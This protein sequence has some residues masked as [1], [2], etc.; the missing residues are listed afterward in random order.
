MTMIVEKPAM[1][2]DG[3]CHAMTKERALALLNGLLLTLTI[4]LRLSGPLIRR[5]Y[6]RECQ[7]LTQSQ[8]IVLAV[9]L[10]R[11]AR[12]ECDTGL[13]HTDREFSRSLTVYAIPSAVGEH[14][15]ARFSEQDFDPL[16]ELLVLETNDCDWMIGTVAR[17]VAFDD[18]DG[19]IKCIDVIRKRF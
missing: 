14:F 19:S 6:P 2:P 5:I 4:E 3:H 13:S 18:D 9:I 12:V 17:F 11:D 1:L 16:V 15:R 7:R 8:H 10:D